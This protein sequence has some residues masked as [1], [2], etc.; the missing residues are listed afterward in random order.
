MRGEGVP[1]HRPE[2]GS[3]R[4]AMYF[5][6]AGA[7]ARARHEASMAFGRLHALHLSGGRGRRSMVLLHSDHTMDAV[8]P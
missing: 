6:G 8:L 4:Q 3:G 7:R 5:V 1:R 2:T